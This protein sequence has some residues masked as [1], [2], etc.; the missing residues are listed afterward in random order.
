[1]QINTA[2]MEL[3]LIT[4]CHTSCV[5]LESN[6]ERQKLMKLYILLLDKDVFWNKLVSS[7]TI[8]DVG[9]YLTGYCFRLLLYKTISYFSVFID[10]HRLKSIF[11]KYDFIKYQCES[12]ETTENDHLDLRSALL[13]FRN[14][15]HLP[16]VISC[17]SRQMFFLSKNL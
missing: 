7:F 8:I 17:H 6:G 4:Y 3:Q 2:P 15:T 10:L 9:V 11:F 16:V 14:F 13:S 12:D 1:M 5:R